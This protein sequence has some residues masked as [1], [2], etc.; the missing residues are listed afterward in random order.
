MLA[1]FV[2]GGIYG[3]D[4]VP[5]V[6]RSELRLADKSNKLASWKGVGLT[7]AEAARLRRLHDRT[8]LALGDGRTFE[9]ERLRD[10]PASEIRHCLRL[11]ARQAWRLEQTEPELYGSAAAWFCSGEF[12]PV[13]TS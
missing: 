10:L 1:R 8:I 7:L 2:F 5:G 12:P 6:E 11:V 9:P 4:G 3:L 13:F